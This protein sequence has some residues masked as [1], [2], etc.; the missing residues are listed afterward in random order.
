MG[1][2]RKTQNQPSKTTADYLAQAV[3]DDLLPEHPQTCADYGF[4]RAV[5]PEEKCNLLGLYI[6]GFH[7][8]INIY[9]LS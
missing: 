4:D 8:L 7:D 5:T 9:D 1:R 3:F 2:R 6:G